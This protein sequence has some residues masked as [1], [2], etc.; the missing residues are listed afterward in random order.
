[1]VG[2]ATSLALHVCAMNATSRFT[3]RAAWLT[4]EHERPTLVGQRPLG[5]LIAKVR[6]VADSTSRAWP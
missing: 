5:D 1:M 2:H 4:S 3:A 6:T